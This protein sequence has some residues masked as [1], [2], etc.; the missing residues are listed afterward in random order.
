MPL[1]KVEVGALRSLATVA[2]RISLARTKNV[3][4]EMMSGGRLQYA[5]G[6]KVLMEG[7][8][9]REDLVQKQ[10]LVQMV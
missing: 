5:R 2:T 10:E 8:A 9:S 3:A 6:V 4:M 1:R 7:S